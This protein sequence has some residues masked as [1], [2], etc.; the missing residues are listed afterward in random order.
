MKIVTAILGA[1]TLVLLAA[2][3]YFQ[4]EASNAAGQLQTLQASSKEREDKISSLEQENNLYNETLENLRR[5]GDALLAQVN[6][7]TEEKK[8]SDAKIAELEEIKAALTKE[9]TELS[10]K[11]KALEKQKDAIATELADKISGISEKKQLELEQ[12][13]NSSQME[14]EKMKS[15]HDQLLSKMRKE[16]AKGQIK[17]TQLSDRLSV[18][19]VDKVLFPSGSADISPEGLK[20]LQRVANIIKT[21]PD[22]IIRVEGHTDNQPLSWYLRNKYASNWELSTARATQVARFLQDKAGIK[23]E[24]LHAVGLSEYHPVADNK[25][26]E[27]RSKNRR[28][29]IILMKR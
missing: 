28:I 12:L 6:Q 22:Q 3:F 19:L 4:G 24:N 10:L 15:T 29:E 2:V 5:D 9:S 1:L 8:R 13:K 23:G 18:T 7:L 27:G 14:L 20:V 17:I 25:S 21:A 16:I 26:E 11:L